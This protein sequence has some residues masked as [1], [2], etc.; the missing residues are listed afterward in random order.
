M[1]CP[2]QMIT[3]KNKCKLHEPS[4]KTSEVVIGEPAPLVLIFVSEHTKHAS[5]NIL[6]HSN[7]LISS[8]PDYSHFNS[9][10]SRKLLC[11]GNGRNLD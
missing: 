9:E 10:K 5:T 2:V 6:L 8:C 4:A 7:I 1:D 3:K 11:K